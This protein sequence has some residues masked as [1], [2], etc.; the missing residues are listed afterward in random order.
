M[1]KMRN[2]VWSVCLTVVILVACLFT[3]SAAEDDYSW[4]GYYISSGKAQ[5]N[6]VYI[7]STKTEITI[8][9]EIDG[10]PVGGVKFDIYDHTLEKVT[11][12]EGI[13]AINGTYNA[14]I[15]EIVIPASATTISDRAFQY[16]TDLEAITV[17]E[18]NESYSSENGVLFDK[19]KTKLIHYPKCKKDTT[20]KVPD[21][22][23][24]I[25]TDAFKENEYLETVELGENLEKIGSAAFYKAKKLSKI[26]F[27]EKLDAIEAN[28][29][30]NCTSLK[31]ITLPKGLKNVGMSA[32]AQC[33]G[34]ETVKWEYHIDNV[35]S[36]IFSGC[37]SLKNVYLSDKIT[38]IPE[39]FLSGCTA[40]ESIDLTYVESIGGDA[41]SSCI[42]LKNIKFSDKIKTIGGFAFRYC[43]AF[44]DF[45]VPESVETI[46]GYAFANCQNLKS[47]TL[48]KG[49]KFL[50]NNV[51]EN[52][53]ALKSVSWPDEIQKIPYSAFM[54]CTGLESI[55]LP[56]GVTDISMSAFKGCS[57]L[58]T[59]V[60]PESLKYIG[61]EAFTDCKALENINFQ[62]ELKDIGNDSFA[63]CTS[64]KEAI[65]PESVTSISS[66][67][68]RGCTALESVSI[69]AVTFIYDATF[70]GCKALKNVTVSDKISII[71][72]GAFAGCTSLESFRMPDAAETVYLGAFKGCTA[73]KSLGLGEKAKNLVLS[74]ICL[75]N[76]IITA[77]ES[78]PNFAESDGILYSKDKTAVYYY[79]KNIGSESFT[80]PEGVTTIKENAFYGVK[81]LSHFTAPEGLVCIETNA[82]NKCENLKDISLPDSLKYIGRYAFENTAA[83]N[84]EANVYENL[85]YIGKHLIDEKACE[86]QHTV[87][88]GT[89]TIADGAFYGS[90]T[91]SISIPESVRTIGKEAFKGSAIKNIVL[92]PSV[93]ELGDSTFSG[94]T[95]LQTVAI[96]GKVSVIPTKAFYNCKSLKSIH[97]TADITE[98]KES[99]F[100]SCKNLKTVYYEGSDKQWAEV[101]MGKNNTYLTKATV[102]FDSDYDHKHKYTSYLTAQA[103]LNKDGSRLYVCRCGDSYTEAIARIEN[104]ALVKTRYRQG[105]GKGV[106]E[107]SAWDS[108]GNKIK[109]FKIECTNYTYIA[110]RH[111]AKVTFTGDYNGTKTFTFDVLPKTVFTLQHRP[112]DTEIYLYWSGVEGATGYRVYKYNEKTK[113]WEKIKST[114]NTYY[115]VKN[116]KSGKTYK[117]AVK[118]YTKIDADTILWGKSL[119]KITVKAIPATPEIKVTSTKAGVATI[120]WADISGESGYQLYYST[121]KDGKYKKVKSYKAGT[122]KATKSKLTSGKKYYFKVRAYNKSSGGTVYGNFSAV[123]SVKIK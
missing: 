47:I 111:E 14:S 19:D 45:T 107:I 123:K 122:V 16:V 31:E 42:K 64:L 112:N 121:S 32:F 55:T 48:P 50:G 109:S 91:V 23:R 41:F 61:V 98:I 66:G 18:D 60:L 68:F 7:P 105:D 52:C 80:L 43:S 37:T 94:C 114:K 28:A 92:P 70:S 57:A 118:A 46:L 27:G 77:D 104:V 17:A 96:R 44:T 83:I 108:K 3:A 99:A 67:A 93:T 36:R 76:L 102:V 113:E 74:D 58:K 75:E 2:A 34:I 63:R 38:A 8:P 115:T 87:K 24:E 6:A 5:I 79:P 65:L 62:R 49:L 69:P 71:H 21:S 73:L 4:L 29:F 95:S 116:L 120:T 40:L 12:S 82:F 53:P 1:K 101:K 97:L 11:F 117:F 59:V 20:Y 106:P 88:D 89:L 110:G 30:Y 35:E 90:K 10:Y 103:T 84:D 51:F 33:Y 100:E 72:A 39:G 78:N 54:N 15:K 85:I 25:S 56:E 9:A 86:V 119:K 26:V 81:K 13:T 22:V